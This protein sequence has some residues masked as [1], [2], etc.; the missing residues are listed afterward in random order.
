MPIRN[1]RFVFTMSTLPFVAAKIVQLG[2]GLRRKHTECS[3]ALNEERVRYM[4]SSPRPRSIDETFHKHL[5]PGGEP[6]L[7]NLIDP[8]SPVA[9]EPE[10]LFIGSEGTCERPSS[11]SQRNEGFRVS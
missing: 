8:R 9:R 10:M 5:N 11:Q 7:N 3:S 1:I 6:A 2:K 4:S